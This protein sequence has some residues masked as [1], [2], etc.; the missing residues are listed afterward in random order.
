MAGAHAITPQRGGPAWSDLA[1]AAKEEAAHHEGITVTARGYDGS[2]RVRGPVTRSSL[3][4]VKG[5]VTTSASAHGTAAREVSGSAPVTNA[6]STRTTCEG[7]R[8]FVKTDGRTVFIPSSWDQRRRVTVHVGDV[9]HVHATGNCARSVTASPQNSRLR[10]LW[11]LS[12]GVGPTYFRAIR[13]GVVRLVISMPMCALPP[14]PPPNKDC[15]PAAIQ[16][17]R[18]RGSAA[19]HQLHCQ[20]GWESGPAA[21]GVS[22]AGQYQDRVLQAWLKTK[23]HDL[24]RLHMPLLAGPRMRGFVCQAV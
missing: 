21:G 14:E 20:C 4:I 19:E 11:R 6:D 7:P 24:V 8:T 2:A 10:E 18:R 23:G 12:R 15:L 22:V 9:V 17:V 3:V 1:A 5:P 16:R 13:P